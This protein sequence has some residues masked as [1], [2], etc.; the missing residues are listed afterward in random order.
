M[1][2]FTFAVAQAGKRGRRLKLTD[3][4]LTWGRKR[5]QTSDQMLAALQTLAARQEGNA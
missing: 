3:F 2:A 5:P 1:V 4:L